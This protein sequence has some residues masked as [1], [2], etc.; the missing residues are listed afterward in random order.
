M[1]AVTREACSS[2]SHHRGYTSSSVTRC[3]GKAPAEAACFNM[4][5]PR[6]R[7]ALSSSPAVGTLDCVLIRMRP[8]AGTSRSWRGLHE[9]GRQF[10]P[11]VVTSCPLQVGRQARSLRLTGDS[12]CHKLVQVSSAG[13]RVPIDRIA[14]RIRAAEASNHASMSWPRARPFAGRVSAR[15]ESATHAS[16]RHVMAMPN[17]LEPLLWFICGMAAPIRLNVA[18]RGESAILT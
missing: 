4:R 12:H 14:N 5:H 9:C 16:A 8:L 17:S 13:V 3:T 6:T 7:R 10:I 18:R 2:V 11:R 1:H 15:F